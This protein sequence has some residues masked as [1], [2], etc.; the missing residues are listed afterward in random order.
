MLN[1]ISM[2]RVASGKRHARLVC[3]GV[4]VGLLP[5]RGGRDDGARAGGRGTGQNPVETHSSSP[6][7]WGPLRRWRLQDTT[8]Y[9]IQ[10]VTDIQEVA[11]MGTVVRAEIL[12]IGAWDFTL[13]LFFSIRHAFVL[14]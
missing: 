13:W 5:R 14:C 3:I 1:I 4:A 9:S 8:E 10:G 11:R 2:I 7:W 6:W 12:R